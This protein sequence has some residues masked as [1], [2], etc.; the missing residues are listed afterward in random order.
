[1]TG[2]CQT[3]LIRCVKERE[4]SLQKQKLK[5]EETIKLVAEKVNL[6][7]YQMNAAIIKKPRTNAELNFQDNEMMMVDDIQK[8]K[9]SYIVEQPWSCEKCRQLEQKLDG[10]MLAVQTK[11]EKNDLLVAAGEIVTKFYKNIYKYAL[12]M[13]LPEKVDLGEFL[14]CSDAESTSEFKRFFTASLNH[15][16]ISLEDFRS[17]RSMKQLRNDIFHSFPATTELLKQLKSAELKMIFHTSS[18]LSKN[19]LVHFNKKQKIIQHVYRYNYNFIL[20]N[21]AK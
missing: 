1:M 5:K 13:G 9:V 15:F 17:L 7:E 21:N 4:L 10:F 8:M 11:D 3:Q 2:L 18:I 16:G 20:S 6:P 19:I 14:E 12:S